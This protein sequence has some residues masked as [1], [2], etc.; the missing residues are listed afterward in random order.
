MFWWSI[1][2]LIP[3]PH[4][5]HVRGFEWNCIGAHAIVEEVVSKFRSERDFL[6]EREV[7]V[8]TR[9]EERKGSG[10]RKTESDITPAVMIATSYLV[11]QRLLSL[12]LAG[13]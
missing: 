6:L 4:D 2:L 11:R 12:I 5:A 9:T 1:W 13:C 10:N 8:G 7:F 3:Q